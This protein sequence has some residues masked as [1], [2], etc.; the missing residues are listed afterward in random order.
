M[1]ILQHNEGAAGGADAAEPVS[2]RAA[3]AN[4]LAADLFWRGGTL[5]IGGGR[6]CIGGVWP[7]RAAILAAKRDLF[8]AEQAGSIRA[9]I[10]DTRTF[11]G[12]EAVPDAV[13]HMLSRNTLGKVVVRITEE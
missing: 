13:E 3:A 2:A 6:R 8:D 5:E 11:T 12:V 9:V 4:A 7:E 10:D 1:R